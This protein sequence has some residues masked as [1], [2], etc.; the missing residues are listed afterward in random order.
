MRAILSRIPLLVNDPDVLIHDHLLISPRV[1]FR[2]L[3]AIPLPRPLTLLIL[4]TFTLVSNRFKLIDTLLLFLI[5]RHSILLFKLINLRL[6]GLL[7]DGLTA[8]HL[9]GIRDLLFDFIISILILFKRSLDIDRTVDF[10]M[11][12]FDAGGY[13]FQGGVGV[14]VH[15]YL[16]LCHRQLRYEFVVENVH[17]AGVAH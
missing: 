3:R 12:C 14:G 13:G 7:Y 9:E 11:A 2:S 16:F 6:R 1:R 15:R 10:D 17:S 4:Q 5:N 8:R